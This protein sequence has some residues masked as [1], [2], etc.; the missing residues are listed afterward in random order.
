MSNQ[1]FTV[2]DAEDVGTQIQV[3]DRVTVSEKTP[4]TI[5]TASQGLSVSRGL[6]DDWE[7]GIKIS[8]LVTSHLN[9]RRP[10]SP[11]VLKKLARDWLP[12]INSGELRNQ[13]QKMPS[14]FF[15]PVFSASSL[16]SSR[17]PSR[18]PN[19]SNKSE[20][21]RAEVT[22]AIRRWKKWP[23]FTK[24]IC[25]E[26]SFFGYGFAVWFD[27]VE[28]KPTFVRQDQGFVPVG[29][30][31]GDD[32]TPLFMVRWDYKVPDLIET[33][34]KSREA[35]HD[36]WKLHA[37]A[38]AINAASTV[39]SDDSAENQ[40]RYEELVRQAATGD[41]EKGYRVVQ[42]W[43]L[44]SV[45]PDQTV[46]HQVFLA[47]QGKQR[48]DQK[49]ELTNENRL[50]FE[51]RGQFESMD[52]VFCVLAFDG[53]DGT[54][55]GSWGAGQMIYETS[56]EYEK[57]LNDWLGALKQ[58]AKIKTQCADGKNP[59]EVRLVVDD[60]MMLLQNG[61][62]AGNTA[63]LISDPQPFQAA[64]EALAE[65][66]RERL[67]NYIPPIPIKPSDIKAAHVNAKMQEQEERRMEVLQMFLLQ[68]GS[69]VRNIERR[70]AGS[71]VDTKDPIVSDFKKNLEGVL[72]DEEIEILATTVTQTTIF[73]FTN[74]AATQRAAFAATKENN[75]FYN[76]RNLQLVQARAA[77]G[78]EFADSILLP[79]DDLTVESLARRE[80]GQETA[81]MMQGIPQKVLPVDADWFHMLELRPQ[82]EQVLLS[83]NIEVGQMLAQ[84]YTQHYIGAVAKKAMPKDQINSE[85][86]F[87]A[88]VEKFITTGELSEEGFEDAPDLIAEV[89]QAMTQQPITGPSAEVTAD[90]VGADEAALEE[91]VAQEA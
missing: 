62:Y 72:T 33:V 39:T 19:A 53:D 73:E 37:V 64:L 43:H 58:A 40:R 23:W 81:A 88:K 68:F 75:P 48:G 50:L 6:I 61:V 41:L 74:V 38:A 91:I 9:G 31:L 27:E 22:T 28:W 1:D 89:E 4:H 3:T 30:E 80:Q 85:K 67:G 63:A 7:R 54:V 77:G 44:F 5:S 32:N 82:L 15:M 59:D 45:D 60:A 34:E 55:Q 79:G 46:S 56:L 20:Q 18:Y 17:L 24:R 12:N 86:S 66:S 57:T 76:Q 16:S 87:I 49:A 65:K 71:L 25:R 78:Q 29:T 51:K 10:R 14:R 83:G 11:R 26:M 52:D 70:L 2:A 21:Y 47:D 13:C 35:E 90:A 84:H 8:R 69:I 42:T 36:T